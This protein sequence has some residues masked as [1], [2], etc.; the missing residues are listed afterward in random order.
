MNKL[1]TNP[2]TYIV[3]AVLGFIA[4][5]WFRGTR[6][7]AEDISSGVVNIAGGLVSGSVKGVS[8][9]LGI[10]DVDEA[11]CRAAQQAGNEWEASKYCTLAQFSRGVWDKFFSSDEGTPKGDIP[12]PFIDNTAIFSTRRP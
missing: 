4:Y 9:N 6:G 7:A 1:L 8:G 2:L 11:K 3:A 5:S 10:P 12:R